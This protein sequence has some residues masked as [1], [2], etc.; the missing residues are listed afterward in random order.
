MNTLDYIEKFL[1]LQSKI[2]RINTIRKTGLFEKYATARQIVDL[3]YQPAALTEERDKCT[4]HIVGFNF[5]PVNV[6][7][8]E[9]YRK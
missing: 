8:L 2:D 7:T 3:N 1:E 9:G 6:V 5:K 4:L